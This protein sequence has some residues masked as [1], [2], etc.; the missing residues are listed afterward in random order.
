MNKDEK[1]DKVGG[2]M[3]RIGTVACVAFIILIALAVR[4]TLA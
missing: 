4:F 2:L 1:W 3:L